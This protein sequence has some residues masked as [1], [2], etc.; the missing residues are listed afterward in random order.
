M[1]KTGVKFSS[2]GGRILDGTGL[3]AVRKRIEEAFSHVRTD[4]SPSERE[5]E[6]VEEVK[7]NIEPQT[8]REKPAPPLANRAEPIL[9]VAERCFQHAVGRRHH[10][11]AVYHISVPTESAEELFD[12]ALK[13]LG[14][15][16]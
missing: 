10:H 6:I 7:I 14:G 11:N 1:M 13:A 5:I 3:A 8:A 9:R 12:A 16:Q 15:E 4:I 2:N